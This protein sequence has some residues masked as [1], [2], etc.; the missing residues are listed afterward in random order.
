V[1]TL[2]IEREIP[3]PPDEVW[4][5]LRH[6]DRHVTWMRDAVR[7]E[8]RDEQRE[9][10]GTSFE[11]LTRVGPFTTRDVMTITSWADDATMG[12]D[13]QGIIA[14]SGEFTLSATPCGT[15]VTWRESL[16]FPWWLGGAISAACARPVLRWIW[17]KNLDALADVVVSSAV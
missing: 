8:F 2:R 12:V 10:V 5:E 9:G 13:H 1:S 7:I 11:C 17:E 3:R 16:R 4:E 14:G 15:L 6:I